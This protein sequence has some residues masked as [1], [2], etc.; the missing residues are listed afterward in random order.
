MPLNR[1]E[2]CAAAL[3]AAAP[4]PRKLKDIV[5]YQDALFYAAF[6]SIVRRADGELIAAFR[7]AP[8]RRKIGESRSLHT[9]PNSYLVLVRSRDGGET[10]T[11]QPEL[12]YAHPFGGSQDPCLTLLRDGSIVCTSYGWL[13]VDAKQL[14][15]R[16]PDIRH[17]EYLFLGGYV[18]R[19]DDGARSWKGPFRPPP[20]PEPTARDPWGD[21]LPFFN[22]GAMCQGRDGRLYWM[23]RCFR[24]KPRQEDLHLLVS[25]DRGETWRYACRAAADDKVGFSETALIETPRGSLVGFVRTANLDSRT[26][27]VRSNDGG[28]SFE[29]WVHAGFQGSPHHALRLPDGRVWLVYGYRHP[30]FGI[31]ARVLNAECTDFAAAPEIVLR[32]DGGNTDVGYPWSAV[33]PGGSVLSVYYFNVA[34]G[35]RFI[36]GTVCAV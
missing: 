12:L 27:V 15:A 21:P 2:L 20:M 31:R 6:P 17:G 24:Q 34:D 25:G 10:W 13:R 11:P 32:D 9:D 33:L 8:E 35:P 1:R 4:P 23:V 18:L 7:R 26:V 29:P 19:S 30:P 3:A 5:I 16:R 28:R 14:A 36:G 22:R